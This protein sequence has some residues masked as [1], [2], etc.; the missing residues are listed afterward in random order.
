MSSVDS[1]KQAIEQVEDALYGYI[2]DLTALPIRIRNSSSQKLTQQH[3]ILHIGEVVQVGYED[4]H[5]YDVDGGL[6]TSREYEIT[7]DIA[8]H[9]GTRTTAVLQSILNS[10]SNRSGLYTKYFSAGNLGYLRGS[11]I[12]RMDWPL[13]KIQF[14]ERSTMS[15]VFSSRVAISDSDRGEIE[16]VQVGS[17][18]VKLSETQVA[19]ESAFDVSHP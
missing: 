9:S 13:D 17:L 2:T 19:V 10:L 4:D 3:I 12:T 15:V 16:T 14:E 11:R 7:V 6:V 1:Y 18:K 8:C 5:G